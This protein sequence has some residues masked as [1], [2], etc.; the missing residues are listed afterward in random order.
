[1]LM[2]TFR[3][4]ERIDVVRDLVD[5]HLAVLVDFFPDSFFLQAAEEGLCHRVVP[6]VATSTHA[7][8]KLV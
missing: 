3:I 1:M 7:G 5:R 2:S 8:L 4:V 6:A